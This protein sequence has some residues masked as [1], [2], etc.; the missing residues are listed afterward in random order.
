MSVHESNQKDN[1]LTG[2]F[3]ES[4]PANC[5]PQDAVESDER[6]AFRCVK[7][8]T[9]TDVDFY[10]YAKLDNLGIE[11]RGRAK[12]VTPCR[13]ASCS[14]GNIRYIRDMIKKFPRFRKSYI[15]KIKLNREAGMIQPS[16]NGHIDFWMYASFNPLGAII[17]DIEKASTYE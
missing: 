1:P 17:Y 3:A 2:P 8:S 9:P 7:S 16:N 4:L 6:V 14:V 5:P 12:G 15:V 10:S 13:W 11:K